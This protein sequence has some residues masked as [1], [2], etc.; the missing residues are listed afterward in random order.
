MYRELK[1]LDSLLLDKIDEDLRGDLSKPDVSSRLIQNVRDYI[2]LHE[3]I[4][5]AT[6]NSDFPFHKKFGR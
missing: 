4:T 5:N 3:Y 6:N 1:A 2:L